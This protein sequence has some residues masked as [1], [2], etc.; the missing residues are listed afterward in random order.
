MI[1]NG[2][3]S[4]IPMYISAVDDLASQPRT[5]RDGDQLRTL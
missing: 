2:R 3:A 4:R 5:E 1:S